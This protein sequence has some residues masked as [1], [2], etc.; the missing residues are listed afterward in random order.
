MQNKLTKNI[1]ENILTKN[2][3]LINFCRFRGWPWLFAALC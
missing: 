1:L 3:F 2:L